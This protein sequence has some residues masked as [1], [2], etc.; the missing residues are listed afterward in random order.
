MVALAGMLPL[1]GTGL[2]SE[3]LPSIAEALGSFLTD[4]TL[5]GRSP[6]TVRTYRA[7]LRRI[8]GHLPLT[9]ERCRV[10]IAERMGQSRNTA[11]TF[12]GALASFT[13]YLSTTHGIPDVME[14]VP[15]P[16][17]VERP[18]R[19]L[20]RDQLRALWLAC[21]DD[22]YR[23]MLLLLMEGLRASEAVDLRFSAISGDSAAIRGKGGRYRHVVLSGALR[24]L[25]TQDVGDER[26]LGYGYAELRRRVRRLGK[27]AG[28]PYPLNPHA[29][30]HAFA[31]NALLEGMDIV[32]LQTLGGWANTKMITEVYAKSARDD[33]ALARS[34]EFALTDRLISR[35]GE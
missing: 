20:T 4:L 22:A 27:L 5:E 35:P 11:R 26:V 17:Q 1:L 13:R 14:Q 7:L 31:S 15:T 19:F 12:A 28:I 29:L 8:D 10:L 23:V 6:N 16:H 24:A 3:S 2:V 25:L 32:T 33:A 9:S 30:R 34:R 18:H 21:P